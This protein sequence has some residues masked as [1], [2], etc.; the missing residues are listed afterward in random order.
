MSF[1]E[2]WRRCGPWLAA[3][4]EH[5]RGSHT[6]DDVRAM[7]E[8]GQARFWAGGRA[9]M[10]TEIHDYPRLRALHFWLAGGDL[11][12]LRDVLR[13]MA[14]N[15]AK[16]R[17]CTRATIAGRRGWARALGYQEIATLCAKELS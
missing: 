15:W 6:L 12:E 3:A 1:E 11:A 2:E 13:P 5:A 7:V 8:T 17:G 14:E 16:A 10:V 4:L 9:A